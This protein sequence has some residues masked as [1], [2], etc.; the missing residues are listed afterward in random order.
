MIA[1]PHDLSEPWDK[2]VRFSS[3]LDGFYNL[4]LLAKTVWREIHRDQ[5][6]KFKEMLSPMICVGKPLHDIGVLDSEGREAA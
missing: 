6:D 5:F 2:I 3:S 1:E 4:A